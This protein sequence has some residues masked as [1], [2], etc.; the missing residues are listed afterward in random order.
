MTPLTSKPQ[1]LT[2]LQHQA[3][4]LESC[5]RVALSHLAEMILQLPDPNAFLTQLESKVAEG[6]TDR[7]C[8][9]FDGLEAFHQ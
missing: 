9:H 5:R 3:A 4:H 2:E 6:L 8:I 7:A 1:Y